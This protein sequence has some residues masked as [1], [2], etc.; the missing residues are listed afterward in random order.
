LSLR[1]QATRP[2]SPGSGLWTLRYVPRSSRDGIL[3]CCLCYVHALYFT[4]LCTMFSGCAHSLAHSLVWSVS[5]SNF[6]G[7]ASV[8]RRQWPL[9]HGDV[10]KDGEE[11]QRNL[12]GDRCVCACLPYSCMALLLWTWFRRLLCLDHSVCLSLSTCDWLTRVLFC[13]ALL[14]S[15]LQPRNCPRT[16][17][18]AAVLD[19][20]TWHLM[21]GRR[22]REVAARLQRR[23]PL[24]RAEYYR[25]RLSQSERLLPWPSRRH[26]GGFGCG[27]LPPTLPTP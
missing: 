19:L 11:R 22:R 12:F 10:S 15:H 5:R 9:V 16:S 8:R 20:S 21:V 13:S 14:C 23:E 3:V 6:A 26:V 18:A 7:C 17:R 27:C 4:V 1:L 2:I 24:F 25:R